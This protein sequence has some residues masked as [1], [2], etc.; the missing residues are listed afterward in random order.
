MIWG[1]YHGLFLVL[2]R[3]RFGSFI[4][5]LPRPLRHLYALLAVLAGW[6]LFRA[7]SFPHAVT[8]LTTMLALGPKAV[9]AQPLARYLSHQVAWSLGFGIIFAAPVWDATKRWLTQISAAWPQ[10]VQLGG[11]AFGLVLETILVV[12]L[13]VISAA[14]LAGGTYNPFIYYRF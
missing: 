11:L 9:D 8:F 2:E 6:V 13:L 7:E 10:P 12:A 14:W 1:L 4:N 3:T 5:W